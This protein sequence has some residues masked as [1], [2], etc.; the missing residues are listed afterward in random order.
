MK[1]TFI[2]H[3]GFAL[4]TEQSILIFDFWM[5]PAHVM[6]SVLLSKKPLY[7]LSSH[8]HEDHFNREIFEWKKIKPNITCILSKE[9]ETIEINE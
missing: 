3:S 7:V 4:E 1:L 9:G 2:F 5:D 8:F 6:E